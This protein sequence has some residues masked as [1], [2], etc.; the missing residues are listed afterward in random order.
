[1]AKKAQPKNQKAGRKLLLGASPADHAWAV[2]TWWLN[3][4]VGLFLLP[5]AGVLT[6]TLFASFSHAA[7]KHSFWASEEF[8]FFTLGAVLW[9]LAFFG[10]IWACGEPRPLRVY[11]F[12]HELTHA[13]WVWIMGGEVIEFEVARHGGYILTDKHNV[14][15]ALAP[16]FYPLYS[17][18]VVVIYGIASVFYDLSTYTPWLFAFIGL[19]WSFHM[20]F[21]VWMIPKGQS[22]LTQHGTFFSLVIIYLMN[23]LLLTALLIFA[24]PEVTISYFLKDLLHNTE[25]LSA[26]LWSYIRPLL[27]SV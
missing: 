9:L 6:Q 27:P 7:V 25:D 16:Y 1:M 24:A 23:L 18:A 20:T 22:D 15:I 11:V 2:P 4:L 19:T 12:G 26:Y 3:T 21:T 13:I 17:L 14:W 5:V 10:S 8:W